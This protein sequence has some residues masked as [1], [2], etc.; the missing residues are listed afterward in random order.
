MSYK[1]CG[2]CK[3]GGECRYWSICIPLEDFPLWRPIPCPSCGGT[4]S[5]IRTDGK[6]FW[7]HCFS[8]HFEFEEKM[9]ERANI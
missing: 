3:L 6:R 4:L 2:N 9:D 7:R 1:S 8:C 5:E